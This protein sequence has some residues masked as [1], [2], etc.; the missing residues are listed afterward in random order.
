MFWKY[1]LDMRDTVAAFSKLEEKDLKKNLPQ[2]REAIAAKLEDS[3]VF[4]RSDY[5][6]RFRNN[7]AS[8]SELHAALD[9]L[10]EYAFEEKVW[11]GL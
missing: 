4:R 2:I 7:V 1:R 10:Y 3:S 11:L 9:D 8:V 6:G 5:P